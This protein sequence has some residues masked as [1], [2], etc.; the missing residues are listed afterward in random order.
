[1]IGHL[2]VKNRIAFAPTHMG[3]G[4]TRGEVT[5]QVLC[6]YSARAKGGVGLIIVEGTGIRC[7]RNPDVGWERFIPKYSPEP[8]R[9]QLVNNL[10]KPY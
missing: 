6:H 10:E 5:D 2:K 3:Y 1:L 7:S 4:S 9:R 8:Q